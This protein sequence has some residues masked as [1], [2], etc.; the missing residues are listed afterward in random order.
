MLGLVV[1]LTGGAA[2]A[3]DILGILGNYPL[4][5]NG[6]GAIG[7]VIV[8]TGV[9]LMKVSNVH[10]LIDVLTRGGKDDDSASIR[11]PRL[12]S[13]RPAPKTKRPG[14]VIWAMGV[15]TLAAV[16]ISYFYLQEA[17]LHNGHQVMPVYVFAAA[18]LICAVVWGVLL[19]KLI[20][21]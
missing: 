8:F 20:M 2:I 1:L 5:G 17:A 6:V 18:A 10:G 3:V 19:A 13:T 7:A 14:P 12:L 9:Y 11:R 21:S 15:A 16:G 4:V